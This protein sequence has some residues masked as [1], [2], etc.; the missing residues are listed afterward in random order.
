VKSI[1][2]SIP[3]LGAK[4]RSG[5]PLRVRRLPGRCLER[6]PQLRL[7]DIGEA[8]IALLPQA[9]GSAQEANG[10]AA[11]LIDSRDAR[12]RVSVSPDGRWLAFTQSGRGITDSVWTRRLDELDARELRTVSPDKNP[13][14]GPGSISRLKGSRIRSVFARY[15]IVSCRRRDSV[16]LSQ[17]KIHEGPDLS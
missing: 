13:R 4:S 12:P 6:N 15:H 16:H 11:R 7:R 9:L 5:T 1:V 8:R 14:P 10:P 3:T 2:R 17:R